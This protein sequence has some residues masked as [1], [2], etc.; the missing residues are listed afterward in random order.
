[1]VANYANYVFD[2]RIGCLVCKVAKIKTGDSQLAE[3]TTFLQDRLFCS[4]PV[5]RMCVA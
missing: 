4:F 3:T 5:S 2:P 1:M